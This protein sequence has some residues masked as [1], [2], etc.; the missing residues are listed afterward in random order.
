M[1]RGFS[2]GREER[3]WLVLVLVIVL[4]L[5]SCACE[6]EDEHEHESAPDA[7]SG[8]QHFASHPS[9]PCARPSRFP[10]MRRVLLTLFTIFL[11]A[12]IGSAWYLYH[13]GFT[14]QWRLRVTEEFRKR[15][16][17]VYLRKLSLDPMRGLVASGVKVLDARDRR[18]VIAEID[19]MSLQVN[20]A[21]LARGEPFLDA[22]DLREAKL[23]LPVDPSDARSPRIEVA[24]LNARLFLPPQQIY[25]ARAEA[26]VFGIRVSASG[27]LINPQ[28]FPKKPDE[29]QK[30][31]SPLIARV[32]EELKALKFE[33]TAPTLSIIFSGDL[34]TPE[35]IFVEAALR[36]ERIRRGNYLLRNLSA[37][38]C[39]RDGFVE[40]KQLTA[41]DTVGALSVTGSYGMESRALDLHLQSGLDLQGISQAFRV[42]PQ[43]SEFV[44]YESPAVDLTFQGVLAEKPVIMV[45][46][47][48]GL[49]KFAFRSV[50]FEGLEAD[51]SW[52]GERWS[53]RE[54]RLL[55]RSG[56]IFGD[57]MLVPGDF[58]A[59]LRSTI[60][61]KPLQPLLSGPAARVLEEFE[62]PEA[63]AVTAE[64]RGPSLS[65]PDCRIT[66][67]L[68][69]G[70][71]S[72]RGVACESLTA[73]FS[74]EDRILSF[75]SGRLRRAQGGGTGGLV[76][77]F[78]RDEVRLQNIRGS[79]FPP[80]IATWI[81]PRLVHD[82]SP[83]RFKAPPNLVVDG[84]VHAKGGK[85]TKL[86]VDV[87]APL[88]MNYTFLGRE[89]SAPQI[90]GRLL[91]WWDRMKIDGLS[92][93]LFGGRM[94]GEA[95]ISLRKE[96]P[97][98]RAS[99]E[100]ENVDFASLTK[101]YFNYDDSQGRL[102][103]RYDFTG[104]GDDAR[105]MRGTGDLTVTDGQVFAI[106]FLGPFSGIL[107]GI[108]PGMGY[109]A[110]RKASATL[111][112]DAGVIET[113][114]LLIEGQ[115]FNMIG[116]GQLF[117]LDDRM[118]FD[119][120]IN[121]Q[122]LPGVLLFPVSKLFEYTSDGTLSKP[123]W[124]PKVVP[125]L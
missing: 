83:Y 28:A 35:K 88:G 11:A 70:A 25:L 113:R 67:E 32:I 82:V 2:R 8:L 90:S 61:P 69:V 44:F 95:E 118:D 50:V 37:A 92:A 106:P 68:R 114:D 94:R 45:V 6:D 13:R 47:H 33:T 39:F 7:R 66:G 124:R 98:H 74:Y 30:S 36:G 81:D 119:M 62:F 52:D 76:F 79:A 5:D 109:Q 31:A 123:T 122:G 34:A 59:Q 87:D 112:I 125:R 65:I 100:A 20:Y 107:N 117:F 49:R 103:G 104:R 16:V 27:R 91:F 15:G 108:V 73:N 116:K 110:A 53:A 23:A 12:F 93:Q 19:E 60:N 41:S 29:E 85:T 26:E 63:P 71:A 80:E 64:V 38:V 77:D 1:P 43:L 86:T 102:N 84:V 96:K 78:K 22:L 54:A 42:L 120:R 115:G 72:Y 51:V 21:N 24:R 99:I 58:R 18:R 97:G 4:V 75:S 40:L 14:K 101:L 57:A 55:H 3:R 10:G 111:T 89:L 48:L 121:A 17:E 46:G 9:T 105:T 56:M